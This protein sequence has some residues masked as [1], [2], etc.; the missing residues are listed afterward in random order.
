M[1][2]ELSQTDFASYADDNIPYVKATNTDE[3]ITTLENDLIQLF[4]WFS[5]NHMEANKTNVFLLT[6][7]TRRFL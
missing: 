5:D 7:I 4:K 3:A 1:F 6:V 2:F